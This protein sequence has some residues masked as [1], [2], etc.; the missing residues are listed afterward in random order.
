[1]KD[2]HLFLGTA[3]IVGIML[4]ILMIGSAVPL[5]RTKPA[6]ILD[7]EKSN[8]V[9]VS[10]KGVITAVRKAC[11]KLYHGMLEGWEIK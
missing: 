10:S 3:T 1:M 4:A 8:G 5:F 11:T 2:W 9:N 6:L 7:S